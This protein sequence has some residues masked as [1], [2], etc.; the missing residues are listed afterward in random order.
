MRLLPKK[1]LDGR[2]DPGLRFL[3]LV[4]RLPPFERQALL[5]RMEAFKDAP[6]PDASWREQ[7]PERCPFA[8]YLDP[9]ETWHVVRG[10]WHPV[11]AEVEAA[12][13]WVHDPVTGTW[14]RL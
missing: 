10:H 3:R 7:L 1:T 11:A 12:T 4:R 9:D 13:V 14:R 6:P 2:R 5:D 8:P